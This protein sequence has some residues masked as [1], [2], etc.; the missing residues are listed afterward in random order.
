[1]MSQTIEWQE[2]SEKDLVNIACD[3]AGS[4]LLFCPQNSLSQS[5]QES[6]EACLQNQSIRRLK[7]KEKSHIKA[8]FYW[9]KLYQPS[10]ES[11]SLETIKGYIEAIHHFCEIEAWQEAL[12]ILLH[13]IKTYQATPLHEYVGM[14]GYYS[15]QIKI[16]LNILGKLDERWDCIW[17]NQLGNAYFNISQY[18]KS[19]ETYERQQKLARKLKNTLLEAKAF[20]GMGIVC[21]CKSQLKEATHFHQTQLEIARQN[22]YESEEIEALNGLANVYL[23]QFKEKKVFAL[24]KEIIKKSQNTENFNLKLKGIKLVGYAYLHFGRLNKLALYIEELQNLLESGLD[25]YSKWEILDLMLSYYVYKGQYETARLCLE[26]AEQVIEKISNNWAK[27]RITAHWGVYYIYL[28]QY[29]RAIDKLSQS[30]GLIR[31]FSDSLSIIY[32]LCNL[33]YCYSSLNQPHI[34]LQYAN[35]ALSLATC[36][37]I[38]Q[39]QEKALAA[40]AYVHW[41][42]RKYIKGLLLVAYVLWLVPPWKSR[43]SQVVFEKTIQEVQKLLARVIQSYRWK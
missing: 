11:S 42:Q 31:Q 25:L 21:C 4:L 41:Q 22:R 23:R 9:L 18:E 3:R 5:S 39:H 36:P 8:A 29:D 10:S 2:L 33:S 43:S 32:N 35:E 12:K 7:F 37:S 27:A 14:I 19:L 26:Q 28:K 13:P 17:L 40:I 20:G 24:Y 15:E 1:M 34:A 6:T 38:N 30:L 16:Y